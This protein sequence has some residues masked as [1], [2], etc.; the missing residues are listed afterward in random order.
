LENRNLYHHRRRHGHDIPWCSAR[1]R[2]LQRVKDAVPQWLT[3]SFFGRLASP[4]L[5][6]AAAAAAAAITQ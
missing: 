5:L 6:A 1:S 2:A 4:A 3:S